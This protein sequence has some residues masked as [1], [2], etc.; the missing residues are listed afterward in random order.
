M[1]ETTQR[2]SFLYVGT[3][4]QANTAG[5][6]LYA[7][8]PGG[9]LE[10]RN[11]FQ[12]G[13][14]PSFLA[15]HP[16]GQTLYTVNELRLDGSVSAFAVEP[17]SG[18]LK[19]L[20][21]QYSHGGD[22]CYLTVDHS[23]RFLLVANYETGSLAI[24][25]LKADGQLQPASQVVQHDGQGPH[26]ERQLGPHA[27]SIRMSP[28]NRHAV[29]CDLGI[30]KI[31]VYRFDAANGKLS[32]HSE[33]TLPPGAGPR[34]LDFHP[35]LGCM[36]V[37]NELDATLTLFDYAAETGAL[38]AVQTLSTLPEGYTATNL[39]AEVAVHPSGK[40]VYASNRG[41]DSLAI[42]TT[43]EATG[44]LT[45]VGHESTRGKTP[46]HFVIDQS[47]AF[48]L[49]ANLES[50]TIVVFQIDTQSGS[51]SYHQQVDTPRPVC[52]KFWNTP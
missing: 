32:P 50:D 16:N 35:S 3:Y 22:P 51:L 45:L 40:F 31:L 49:A 28:D 21:R 41:H 18:T 2:T 46:R 48:L 44:R 13:A 24:Y 23:G 27:H 20:N 9:A 30:D 17:G 6:Y 37:L 47:G 10:R 34:H 43:D 4:A 8:H 42:Y 36:Y 1:P 14:N 11:S 15:L 29:S 12:V 25:P 7:M 38:T 19:F 39:C 52:L 5:I 33:V 26:P